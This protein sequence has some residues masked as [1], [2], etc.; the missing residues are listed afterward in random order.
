MASSAAMAQSCNQSEDGRCTVNVT[1]QAPIPFTAQITSSTPTTDVGTLTASDLVPGQAVG[2]REF[3]GPTISARANFA[4]SL[5]IRAGSATWS[6][7]GEGSPTKSASD[8]AWRTAPTNAY[9]AASTTGATLLTG[10]L[11]ELRSTPLLFRTTW[12][13]ATEPPG[14]YALPLTLTLAAP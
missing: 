11:G 5:T 7:T 10:A 6:Y 3:T 4:W 2:T 12:R 1:L 14:S 9:T 13:W 8:L